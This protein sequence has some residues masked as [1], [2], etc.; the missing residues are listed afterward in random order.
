MALLFQTGRRW[1]EGVS[2]KLKVLYDIEAR[3]GL[4]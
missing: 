2:V 1:K 3:E 4:K